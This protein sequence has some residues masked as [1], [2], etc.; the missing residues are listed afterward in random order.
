MP[1]KLHP[2]ICRH[3]QNAHLAAAPSSAHLVVSST[4]KQ[5][6]SATCLAKPKLPLGKLNGVQNGK[7]KVIEFLR[8]LALRHLTF[9]PIAALTLQPL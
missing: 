8:A 7:D 6:A 9:K 4:Q 1:W 3:L 5:V 2:N